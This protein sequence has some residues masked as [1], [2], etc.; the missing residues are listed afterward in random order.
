MKHLVDKN[1]RLLC[2]LFSAIAKKNV[3]LV[4]KHIVGVLSNS[5]VFILNLKLAMVLA[6]VL[7][8]GFVPSQKLV[9]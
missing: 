9:A 7:D 3:L 2:I 6:T 5:D 1:A 4:L 8:S